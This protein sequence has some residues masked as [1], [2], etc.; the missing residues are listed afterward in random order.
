ME[1][2]LRSRGLFR[3]TSRKETEP[4]DDDKKIKWANRCDEARG[5]I[6]MSIS[7]DLRFHISGI[8]EPDKAWEKLESVFGKHN[9]IRGHQLENEL[10]S[11]NPNDFS[12]I[13]DYLSK[14]KTLRLLCAE[15]KIK[16]EDKQCIYHI[17]SKLG[18]AYSV[19]VSTFY[20]MKESLTATSYQEP[21]L[22]SFCD[23]LI[24][25]QDKLI[26]LGIINNADTSGKALLSQQ[27]EKS[28]PPKKQN[29]HNKKQN[30]KGPKPSQSAP[31]L[32][33]DKG[34]K[35]KGKKTERHCNFCGKD[36][37]DESKC[38]KKMA[39]LEAAM[40]KHHISLDSSSESTSHG[41]ALCASGYSYTASSSSTSIEWLID[42]G[43]SYHMAKDK[44]IF[45]TMHECNTK[46]IFVGDDRSL[47]VVGSGTV[48]VENGHFSDVLCVPKISC[49][50]LSVYQIT[51]S[52]EGKTVTFTP[53]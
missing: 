41:H 50:L 53:H 38:F 43:A 6:G 48:P 30:N 14:Y 35:Q 1:D 32:K 9:E 46:Q 10:L 5:L 13:Q 22:E 23:S 11:L 18:P 4:T 12:C 39:A 15:C 49:N 51:H 2:V 19:F 42:S 31:P 37:H 3:I 21:S 7:T 17:L 44:A 33:N 8:D 26:H 25:E 40:K 29:F 52:G 36:N 20:S 45:S 27:K 47:S 28:K 24:R 34:S 16:K